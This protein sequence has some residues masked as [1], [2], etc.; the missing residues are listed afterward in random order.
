MFDRRKALDYLHWHG[1]VLCKG[2]LW[3]HS[4]GEDALRDS[5]AWQAICYLVHQHDYGGLA[6]HYN[7]QHAGLAQR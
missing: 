1:W 2:W 6:V 7:P 4:R 3:W 5:Y